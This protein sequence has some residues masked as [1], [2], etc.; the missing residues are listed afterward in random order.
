MGCMG[1][2]AT[3]FAD[4]SRS[5]RRRRGRRAQRFYRPLP[6]IQALVDI[7][8]VARGLWADPKTL[9]LHELAHDLARRTFDSLRKT[10]GG[11]TSKWLPSSLEE[12]MLSQR[13]TQ[14]TFFEVK[15]LHYV[16]KNGDS[17]DLHTDGIT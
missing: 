6:D 3:C 2:L 1:R 9:L 8:Q 7:P 14:Q 17:C 16:K 4:S 12:F 11:L 13:S 10:Y 15:A 5:A